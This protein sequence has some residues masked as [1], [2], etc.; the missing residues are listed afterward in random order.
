MS[1]IKH[2]AMKMYKRILYVLL[3]LALDEAEW[4]DSCPDNFILDM[5]GMG[6]WVDPAAGLDA[7]KKEK[8]SLFLSFL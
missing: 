8:K 4:S 3:I 1:L 6:A 2:H 7:M 5:K